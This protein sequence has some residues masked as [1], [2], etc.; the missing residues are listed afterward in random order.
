MIH[1]QFQFLHLGDQE[2]L[3]QKCELTSSVSNQLNSMYIVRAMNQDDRRKDYLSLYIFIDCATILKHY[4]NYYFSRNP[5]SASVAHYE[6]EGKKT[7]RKETFQCHYCDMFFR[8]RK[9]FLKHVKH[10][11]GPPGFIYSFQ[12]GDVEC[13]ENYLR[14]TKDFLLQWWDI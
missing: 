2:K 6:E 3:K 11:S 12:D 14:H 10:C 4:S 1:K 5:K 8:Y 13:Y 7:K 9:K